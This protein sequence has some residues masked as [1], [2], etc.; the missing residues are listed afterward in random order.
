MKIGILYNLVEN[1]E[2]GFEID[3]LSDNEI[4]ETVKSVQIALE[5]EHE[6]IPVR[7]RRDLISQLTHK[8]FDFIFNLC[9]GI[10]GNVKGEYWVTSVLD[11]IGIPYTGSDSL[12]LGLCLDKI[13]TK[14]LLIANNIKTPKYQIFNAKPDKFNG[15]YNNN[16]PGFPLKFPLKFPLIVKPSNED[17]SV[18]ITVD[19][20]V[21]NEPQLLERAGFII[22]NYRQNALVEEYIDGRELNAA[23]I[24]N[25]DSVEVLPV[26]EIAFNFN[27][28]ENLPKIVDYEAKWITN[29]EMFKKT[30]GLCPA[31]LPKNIE[32]KIKKISADVYNIMGCRDYAR[33]DFRLK[34]G[35]P[36][37]L[38]VN[39]NPSISTDS[40]FVRS[41]SSEGLSY[42]AL[43]KKILS[44]S[45]GRYKKT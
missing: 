25:G 1:K 36:Y 31:D 21:Y 23:V 42:S 2:R 20:V 45:M 38:E 6:V 37:V 30:A 24:G 17:G 26:S 22:K 7:M 40:G 12:T 14:Q 19:S 5:K 11:M 13:K 43:I 34:G 32:S 15:N 9:E 33:V 16:K 4:V 41:A 35:I 39:P 44:L 10:D 8:S 18:G 28:N 29:S 27:E 3:T